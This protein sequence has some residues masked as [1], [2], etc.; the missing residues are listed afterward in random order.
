MRFVVLCLLLLAG[1]M[2]AD[3]VGGR[4]LFSE[5]HHLGIAGLP[6]WEEFAD[7]TP[8]GPLLDF[9]FTAQANPEEFT[10][11]IRQRNVKIGWTVT[12]NGRR[13][14]AL[15][16]L[17]QALVLALPVPANLLRDGEN[18]L[19]ISR[20]PS[21][22]L[23]QINCAARSQGR[24]PPGGGGDGGDSGSCRARNVST[25][26]PSASHMRPNSSVER[27]RGSTVRTSPSRMRSAAAV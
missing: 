19:T 10:L 2:W 20:V 16:T 23:A 13:I 24:R 15:E 12:L 1:R 9:C 14:G 5:R 25:K 8:H 26:A 4:V 18:R 21:P 11:L 7:S 22:M 27:G 6:E 17:G 3:D